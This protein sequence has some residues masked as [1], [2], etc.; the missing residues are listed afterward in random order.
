MTTRE[1]QAGRNSGLIADARQIARKHVNSQDP[2][3]ARLAR[4][5]LDALGG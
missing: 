2:E 4:K 5:I 3:I 1:A